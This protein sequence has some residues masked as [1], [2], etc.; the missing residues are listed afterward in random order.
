MIDVKLEGFKEINRALRKMPID[1]E[2]KYLQKSVRKSA[3]VVQKDAMKRVPV[4]T[5]FLKK[6]IL[7]RKKRIK[8]YFGEVVYQVG[9]SKDAFY[10]FFIEKG[11]I[12]TGPKGEGAGTFKQFRAKAKSRGNHVPAK[13]FLRPSFDKN[14]NNIIS[15]LKQELKKGIAKE[16]RKIG[17]NFG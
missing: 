6:N 8:G 9:I 4:K 12:P 16:A 17:I 1:I 2:K 11:W 14:K 3:K 13:P 10:G 5:G 7:L 15:V